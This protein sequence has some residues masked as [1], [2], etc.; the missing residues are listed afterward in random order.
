MFS[1][2]FSRDYSDSNEDENDERNSSKGNSDS[3]QDNDVMCISDS[4]DSKELIPYTTVL[5]EE[6]PPFTKEQDIMKLFSSYPLVHIVMAKR[7]KVFTAYAKFHSA[8]DA[9]AAVKNTA[10]HKI[11][12]KTVYISPCSEEEFETARKEFSGEL[13]LDI[14][15]TAG[16]SNESNQSPTDENNKNISEQ[17]QFLNGNGNENDNSTDYMNDDNTN[18]SSNQIPEISLESIPGVNLADPRINTAK[19]PF[20]SNINQTNTESKPM[21]R[22]DP[23]MKSSIQTPLATNAFS[24]MDMSQ[25]SAMDPNMIEV[26]CILIENME[27]R[28][29]ESEIIE[30]ISDQIHITAL[31]VQLLVNERNQT[32][33]NGFVQFL[34]AEQATKAVEKLDKCQFKS[35]F[36]HVSLATWQQIQITIAQITQ[37]LRENGFDGIDTSGNIPRARNNNSGNNKFNTNNNRY[38]SSHNNRMSNNRSHHRNGN[39]NG[40]SNSNNNNSNF[41]GCVVAMSNVP[42]KASTEDIL[43]FFYDFDITPSDIIRRYND[44]GK[45]TGDARVRFE[46]PAEARRAID[47]RDNCR[48]LNRSIYLTLL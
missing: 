10:L 29:T 47:L 31:R 39:G 19:F 33:G 45:P 16:K 1:I 22:V 34:N 27:Y 41:N 7:S 38:N 17:Q 35:R 14:G 42:Y 43:E 25:T 2:Q 9:K 12:F 3:D 6:L 15:A 37:V 36:V 18:H 13:D 4:N 48:I 20:L 44:E 8:D 11:S 40:N 21:E 5:I 28:T 46:T 24:S 30:W 32:N 23:R 26:C